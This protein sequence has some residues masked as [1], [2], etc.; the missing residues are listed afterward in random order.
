MKNI[1]DIYELSP[2]QQGFLFHLMYAPRSGVYV[3]QLNFTF[4]GEMNIEDFHAAWRKVVA[5]HP[6]LRTAIHAKELEKPLQVVHRRVDVPLEVWDWTHLSSKERERR[7]AA[8]LLEDRQK[9]F[10]LTRPPLMRLTLI[11]FDE[12]TWRFAWRFPHIAMDG[13]SFGVAISEFLTLYKALRQGKTPVLPTARPYRDYVAWWKR[14]KPERHETFWR[15]Y[16]KGYEPP[17]PLMLGEPDSEA[18]VTHAFEE[19]HLRDLAEPLHRFIRE[20]RLTMN[21][22]IQAAWMVVLGRYLGTDDVVAGSTM[23][24]QPVDLLDLGSE[25]MMGPMLITLPVRTRLDPERKVLEW[26]QSF[27]AEQAAVREHGGIPLD[28]IQ[29][30]SE[31]SLVSRL[32]E[33]TVAFE[34]VPIPEYSLDEVGLSLLEAWYDGRPHYPLTLIA[35][36]GDYMPLRLV[37]DRRRFDQEAARRFLNNVRTVLEAFTRHPDGRLS[38]IEVLTAEEKAFLAKRNKREHVPVDRPLHEL[39]REQASRTPDRIA[40]EHDDRSWTYR[41][42]DELT[43]RIARR[44][45]RS[46]V[47]TEDRVALLVDRSIHTVSGILGILKAG[48]AYVPLDPMYPPERIRLI[49]EDAGASVLLAE[50]DLAERVA[51]DGQVLRL[52]AE[53]EWIGEEGSPVE[54][55]VKPEHLAYVIYTSGTTGR[56]KGTLVTHE[57]VA[58]L[59]IGARKHFEF[60]EEDVWPLFHSFAFDV[61][62][63]EMWGAF[64]HGGKLVI[65]PWWTC[66]D[67]EAFYRLLLEKNVTVLNQTPSAFLQ[68]IPVD[69]THPRASDLKLRYVVFAGERLDIP[70]LKPWI[71]RHG[72]ERPQLINMYG[73]TEITVH[74]TFRRVT[75]A[76]LD[77]GGRSL[78]GIPLP[79]LSIYLLDERQRPVPV[80][81]PGEICVAGAGVARGYLNRP[82]LTEARFV[83]DP[84]SDEPG[85]MMYRSGD[86][87]RYLPDGDMEFLGR[88]DDQVKIRGFRVEPGEIASVLRDHP[89]IKGAAVIV[90]EDTPGDKRL[91]AY[92]VPSRPVEVSELRDALRRHLPEYMVP[93]AWV[94][95]EEIPLTV[96]GKLDKRALPKPAVSGDD[97][98]YVAPR[99]ETEK[100][101]CGLFG[102]M[103]RLK[104]VGVRDHLLDLGLHSLLAARAV[105]RIRQAMKKELPLPKLFESPTVE[106]LAAWLDSGETGRTAASPDVLM[107]DA[108]LDGHIRPEAPA[109]W[110]EH[111]RKVLLT[112]GTGFLGGYLLEQLLR[113]TDAEVYC[114]VRAKDEEEGKRKLTANLQASGVWEEAFGSRILPVPGD[115]GKPKLGLTDSVWDRLS[116]EIDE[117][118]HCGARVNFLLPYEQ[119]KPENVDGTREILRFACAGKTKVLHHVSTVGTVGVGHDEAVRET[120]LIETPPSVLLSGYAE[121][122]WVAERMVL[123]ARERGLPVVI[124]RPGRVAGHSESGLWKARDIVGQILKRFAVWGLMPKLDLTLDLVPVDW[125]SGALVRLSR[126]K[127]SLGKVFHLAHP[128]PPHFEV[129]G[130]A[131]RDMDDSFRVLSWPEWLEAAKKKVEQGSEEDRTVLALF[132]EFIDRHLTGHRDPVFD[133]SL[134]TEG[135]GR[136]FPCPDMT[137]EVLRRFMVSLASR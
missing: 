10:D 100:A 33:S 49:L 106:A 84:F 58:R 63:W 48:A 115:L 86:L 41:E 92:Y 32:F 98:T 117:I 111:P 46:G 44:L 26:L 11:R 88:M 30:W 51:F 38:D 135:V 52:D 72:D 81:A 87:A 76:D 110:T 37:Y 94:E 59:V 89:A 80:G 133:T 125:V 71:D 112:G 31:T 99:T 61:S 107:R 6:I 122:K 101:L 73:I 66:R 103:L 104:R 29:E 119:L 78:I 7:Y 79:D 127:E 5:R 2:I 68:L 114:L 128:N 35:L 102:E 113:L 27:Q 4:Q 45:K 36:P 22:M 13:W 62:V 55:S 40:V 20:G 85:A 83:P 23:A 43:N 126:K 8:F 95:L 124:Y 130:I 75:K 18:Q 105:A 19:I 15:D 74:A 25:T 134:T 21:T 14:A 109:E 137:P 123:Q 1:E 70:S 120:D 3:E 131:A 16:L 136:E 91:V 82:E 97:S 121:S 65:V 69:N 129:L 50:G 12:E 34:N 53:E 57:N 17:E 77:R 24:H 108:V 47:K 39:F 67:P 42:L 54:S 116:E 60:T 90:R 93:V 132:E 56:P 96:N 9:D 28:K 118:Y 64:L